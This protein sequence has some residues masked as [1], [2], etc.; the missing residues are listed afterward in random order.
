MSQ[1]M[2]ERRKNFDSDNIVSLGMWSTEWQDH[3]PAP[4]DKIMIVN[5]Y[6][7]RRRHTVTEL[8]RFYEGNDQEIMKEYYRGRTDELAGWIDKDGVFYGCNDM[9]HHICCDLCFN[10]YESEAEQA[11]YIKIFYDPMFLTNYPEQ[12]TEKGYRYY[13]D[14]RCHLT[15]AQKETLMERGFIIED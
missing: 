6:G 3:I 4:G 14:R 15:K 11:G 13:V 10:L 12:C 8:D 9:E 1:W 5:M 2:E 7:G